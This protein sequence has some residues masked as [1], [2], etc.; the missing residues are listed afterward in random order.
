MAIEGRDR[1][2]IRVSGGSYYMTHEAAETYN[3]CS[4]ACSTDRTVAY[5]GFTF[6]GDISAAKMPPACRAKQQRPLSDASY[7]SASGNIRCFMTLSLVLLQ[8]HVP[9][10]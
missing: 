7:E 2:P 3:F 5:V 10:P 4:S 9:H 8:M 1:I 6:R